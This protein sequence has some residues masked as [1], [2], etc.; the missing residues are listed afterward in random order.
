MATKVLQ[1]MNTAIELCKNYQYNYRIHTK[2]HLATLGNLTVSQAQASILKFFEE[3][4]YGTSLHFITYFLNLYP[5]AT[6]GY[7]PVI[8]VDDLEERRNMKKYV[9]I[10]DDRVYDLAEITSKR[11]YVNI[12]IE[13]LC[14]FNCNI[15]LREYCNKN[16]EDDE[17]LTILPNPHEYLHKNFNEY[18]WLNTHAILVSKSK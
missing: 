10:I 18:L 14:A 12:D 8:D 15:P 5:E 11:A 16:L 4:H 13:P 17:K 2:T 1:M 9:A 7:V 3:K 6:Y